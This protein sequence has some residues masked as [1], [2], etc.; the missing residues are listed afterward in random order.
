MKNL[1]VKHKQIISEI[2]KDHKNVY[3]FGSRA[4]G[5]SKK[6]SDLDLCIKE[7]I[8]EYD[9]E[10]LREKFSNSDLPFKV[11][12]ILYKNTNDSFKKIIDRDAIH[13]SKFIDV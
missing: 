1:S 9:C 13:I 12:V 3:V 6:F 8:S 10:I 4:K 7:D 5:S 2:I 11:D